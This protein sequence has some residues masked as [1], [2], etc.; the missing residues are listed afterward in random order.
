MIDVPVATAASAGQRYPE[1]TT[2]MAFR[3]ANGIIDCLKGHNNKCQEI[4]SIGCGNCVVELFVARS[5]KPKIIYLID[6]ETTPGKHHHGVS[7]TG[8]GYNSL[9]SAAKFLSTNLEYNP[10][11]V[12]INPSKQRLGT[13]TARISRT[14]SRLMPCANSCSRRGGCVRPASSSRC[15]AVPARGRT[16]PPRSR[17][18]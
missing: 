8:A 2:W 9:E 3:N 6:I 15:G 1:H 14:T 12:Q 17:C 10:V 11:I 16:C 18:T 7:N 13:K 4:A 5:L